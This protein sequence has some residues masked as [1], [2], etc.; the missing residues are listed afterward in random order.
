M[1][2]SSLLAVGLYLTCPASLN[3]QEASA[4]RIKAQRPP[5]PSPQ[6]GVLLKRRSASIL[7]DHC[8]KC[9]GSRKQEGGLRLDSREGILRGTDAGPIVVPGHPEASPLVEAIGHD[10]A[11]KMRSQIEA[12]S[13]G[14]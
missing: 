4:P 6:A 11:I 7:V 12:A 8:F 5:I 13:S 3:A 9:H 1:R 10:A 2:V 14:N